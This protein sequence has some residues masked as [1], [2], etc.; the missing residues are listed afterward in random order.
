MKT[1]FFN[2][3]DGEIILV[4]DGIQDMSVF[5]SDKDYDTSGIDFI[6]VSKDAIIFRQFS[7]YKVINNQLIKK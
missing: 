3:E 5:E 1:V 2:I 4:I 6:L 7:K